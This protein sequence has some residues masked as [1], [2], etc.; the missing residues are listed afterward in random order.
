MKER[1]GV[2]LDENSIFD[3][4]IKRLHEYK[5]QQMNALYIIW[6]YKQIKAGRK[7]KRP[8]PCCLGRK[9]LPPISSPRTL[10]T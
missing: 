4:Q 5:R 6:K 7:P 2:D 9:R 1:E 10:S 3:I 8:L